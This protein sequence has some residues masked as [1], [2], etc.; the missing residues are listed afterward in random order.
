MTVQ[1]PGVVV[2]I[3]NYCTADLT[4]DCLR[5]LETEI[6]QFPGSTVVVADNASPDNSGARIARAIS[7]NGWAVLGPVD[8]IAAQWRLRI[9]QQQYYS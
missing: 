2:A 1:R 5:S 8:A 7:D 6:R 3:V 4:I 9:W